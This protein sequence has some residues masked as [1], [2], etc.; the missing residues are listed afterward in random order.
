MKYIKLNNNVEM[1]SIGIGTF[2]LK[3]IDAEKSVSIALNNGYRL[4][5]TANFYG[6]EKAVGRAIRN[7]GVPREE[8][9]VSSKIWPNEYNNEFSVEETLNRLGL[10]YLDLLFL[11][12]PTGDILKGY[13]QLE[14]AYKEGKI[15]AIGLSNFEDK[16]LDKILKE[17]EIK[18]QIMQLECNPFFPQDKFRNRLDDLGIVIMSWYPLGGK[19]HTKEL[20]NNEIIVS[21]ANKYNKAPAQIIL[22]WHIQ[23][24][25][26]VIPGS[27]NEKH[28]KDNI[29]LFDFEL[30]DEDMNEI[31]KINNGKKRFKFNFLTLLAMRLIKPRYEK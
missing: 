9:F 3:P 6:N 22:R 12:Q 23:M 14:K 13:K 15:R 25:F 2:L 29:D 21:L 1:P 19:G 24:G 27:K 10:D 11:H 28:I 7:S 16:F 4:I 17:A 31:A 20:L 8:I 30:S 5:D 18:P 26:S